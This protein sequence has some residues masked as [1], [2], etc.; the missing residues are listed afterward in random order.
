MKNDV[1]LDMLSGQP[2]TRGLAPSR[3]NRI[4]DMPSIVIL[5]CLSLTITA[6]QVV[7]KFAAQ[8]SNELGGFMHFRVLSLVA[9]SFVISCIGQLV[10]LYVLKVSTLGS[11]YLFLSLVFV[12]VPLCSLFFFGERMTM[13]QSVGIGFILI[14]IAIQGYAGQR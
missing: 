13:P 14:G 2:T 6:A 11:S 1:G 4:L 7:M 10:W 3:K 5:L 9:A 12:L 8:A